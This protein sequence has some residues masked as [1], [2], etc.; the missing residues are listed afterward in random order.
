[1]LTRRS[2]CLPLTVILMRPSW[3]RRFSEMSMLPMI[4]MREIIG[5]SSRRGGLSRST[6]T[7]SMR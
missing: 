6:S 4:L 1:M 7:P 3:G 2:K 5:A